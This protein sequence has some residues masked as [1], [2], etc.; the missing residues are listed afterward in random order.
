LTLTTSLP[1]QSQS[2]AIL[3]APLPFQPFY[4]DCYY[5]SLG[6]QWL[7]IRYTTII[8]SSNVMPFFLMM[9]PTSAF[10]ARESCILVQKM[11]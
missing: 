1:L 2:A 8:N 9:L 5:W 7:A 4:H 6:F 10:V 11:V 3:S